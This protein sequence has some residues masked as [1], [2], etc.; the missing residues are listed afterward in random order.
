MYR[1]L[2]A[3]LLALTACGL[4]PGRPLA[5]SGGQGPTVVIDADPQASDHSLIATFENGL[6]RS[7]VNLSGLDTD[8]THAMREAS[9]SILLQP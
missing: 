5:V 1:I 6:M 4:P 9:G 2:A 8:P 7:D 3:G